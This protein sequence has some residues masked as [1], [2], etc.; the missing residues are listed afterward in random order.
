MSLEN[1]ITCPLIVKKNEF[2]GRIRILDILKNM[3]ETV[4]ILVLKNVRVFSFIRKNFF[5]FVFRYT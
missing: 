5:V 4:V 3:F 2:F 1:G